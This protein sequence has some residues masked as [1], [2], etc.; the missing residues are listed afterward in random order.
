MNNASLNYI[1]HRKRGM[2]EFSFGMFLLR[3][4]QTLSWGPV[5]LICLVILST[6]CL[7][8]IPYLALVIEL[9]LLM[10]YLYSL[11]TARAYRGQTILNY[12]QQAVNIN[13]PLAG[14]MAAAAEGEGWILA[15]RLNQLSSK[16]AIGSP[17]GEALEQ[18][19]PEISP[20]ITGEIMM[21]EKLGQLKSCL[22]RIGKREAK[23]RDH[24]LREKSFLQFYVTF[25]FYIWMGVMTSYLVIVV[26][27]FRE[28]FAD[29]P[30]Q[31]PF[32]T[33]WVFAISE[34]IREYGLDWV[35]ALVWG[36][37]L[38]WLVGRVW[39]EICLPGFLKVKARNPITDTLWWYC[40]GIRA[41]IESRGLALMFENMN[42]A[43]TAGKSVDKTILELYHLNLNGHM[44][45]KF[46]RLTQV[47]LQGGKFSEGVKQARF[48]RLTQEILA[49][50]ELSNNLPEACRFLAQYYRHKNTTLTSVIWATILPLTVLFMA[51]MVGL[52]AWSMF[53]P[54]ISLIDR[55]SDITTRFHS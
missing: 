9:F 31:I 22:N 53:Q 14:F 35:M 8:I 18:T 47:V 51:I 3:M 49:N 17:L 28:I 27:K 55:A 54:L 11:R 19:V 5:A 15:K 32:L 50:S 1:T 44:Q 29:F 37:L 30:T 42:E 33:Q 13:V 4:V 21:A 52:A 23:S 39:L 12:L 43:L 46:E 2:G 34:V 10:L 36:L 26:P 24:N 16:L 41:V 25:M 6:P 45:H 38:L 40:P 7:F 20:Q 48:P